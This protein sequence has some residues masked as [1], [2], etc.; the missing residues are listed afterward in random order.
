[1]ISRILHL[2]AGAL[3]AAAPSQPGPAGGAA[4]DP[5]ELG[6]RYT[7]W[8][9]AGE[10]GK[11]WERFTPDMQKALGSVEA[12]RGFRDQVAAQ[13]GTEVEVLSEKVTPEPPFQVYTRVIRMSKAPGTVIVQ[14]ALDAGGRVAGFFVRPG[15]APSSGYQD[16]RTKTPLRLPFQGEWYVFWGGRTIDENYHV[17]APDQRFAYD[18]LIFRDG[19]SHTGD[20]SA[21]EQYHCFGQPILAPAAGTVAVVVEGIA[22]NKPGEMNPAQAAG[23]YLVIDHGNGEHS[24]LAH[25]KKGS[26][27]VRKGDAVQPG[28]RLGLCGNSGNSSEPHLH[29]HLQ[30]TERFGDGEGLPAFF[31][32]YVADGQEVQR[33]EPRRGQTVR[34]K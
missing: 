19:R 22:D 12:L 4:S 10:A 33:G 8:F 7:E 28:D 3:L 15:E 5:A 21:N 23:N 16:Y 9:Y 29:Y 1:M 17:V 24:F 6:R 25:F 20:G 14:W 2:L 31:N 11:L 27:A 32:G 26:I 30:T 34:P 13:A 18:F